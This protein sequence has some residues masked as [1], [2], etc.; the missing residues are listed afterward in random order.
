MNW[1]RQ[2]EQSSRGM[3]MTQDRVCQ[4]DT[5][6]WNRFWTHVV[7]FMQSDWIHLCRTMQ[8]RALKPKVQGRIKERE[9]RDAAASFVAASV[10]KGQKN[11]RR[12]LTV[13]MVEE[14]WIIVLHAKSISARIASVYST[15]THIPHS[16]HAVVAQVFWPVLGRGR[17]VAHQYQV[18]SAAA[19]R[20]Q[21]GSD[22]HG[23]HHL[24]VLVEQ[25]LLNYV[26]EQRTLLKRHL[27]S[28][29]HRPRDGNARQRCS[30][31]P[32]TGESNQESF[33]P[34]QKAVMFLHHRRSVEAN[35]RA[36]EQFF[37]GHQSDNNT[38]AYYFC[39]VTLLPVGFLWASTFC[40]NKL[41][42]I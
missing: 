32:V 20:H 31:N 8:H 26:G 14:Q 22:V 10:M 18:L 40:R 19:Q 1:T 38:N 23:L 37:R 27:L 2:Q 17:K 12:L 6:C 34:P 4:R 36:G 28:H 5:T 21:L 30:R 16:L 29:L 33:I 42:P 41:L 25:Y 7:T 11:Q 15:R 24:L 35:K 3:I 13:E 9:R 39:C